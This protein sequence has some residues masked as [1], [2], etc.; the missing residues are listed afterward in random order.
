MVVRKDMK[1]VVCSHGFGVDATGRGMFT[2]IAEAFPDVRFVMFNYNTVDE[3]GN[4][5][6]R[7]LPEQAEILNEQL[8]KAEGDVT[9]LC[10]SK[11]C[12]VGAMADLSNVHDVI[13]LAP[14]DGNAQTIKHFGEKF[15]SREGAVFNPDGMSTIPRRDGTTTYVSSEYLRT[16]ADLDDARQ[17]YKD[18]AAK[19]PLTIISAEED[20]ILGRIPFTDIGATVITLPG[21]HDFTGQ[22][23]AGL[24]ETLQTLL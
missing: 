10:H 13:F 8:A 4:M 12:V 20:E 5:T 22:A 15:G 18:V 3:Q 24:I 16:Q 19:H 17:L 7:P 1:T 14:P 11:G 6:V 2:D 21:N 23:R 9:L